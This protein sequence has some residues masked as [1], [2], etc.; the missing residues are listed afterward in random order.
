M[1]RSLAFLLFPFIL[2]S[3]S[4]QQSPAVSHLTG[5]T[6]GTSYQVSIPFEALD[7]ATAQT[8]IDELLVA[9]NQSVSTY[10][11]SS[12]ISTINS[13]PD[14]STVH[15]LD[16]MFVAIYKASASIFEA[17]NG[18]FNPAIG[19]LV[20]AYGFGSE[21][22]QDLS[23]PVI[24][25][26]LALVNFES[27]SLNEELNTLKKTVPGT[28]L[29]FSA[30]AKGYGV[31]LVGEYL[32][33]NGVNNYFVEIGGEVRT[34]G[35]HPENRP[36]KLG[37]DVPDENP[38]PNARP[39]QAI[40][41]MENDA[42]ATS[43]NYR[44]FYVKDGKKYVHTI[45]PITGQPEISNLLSVTVLANDCATAD[46]YATA[47]MVMGL[48]KAKAFA[49]QSPELEA[50]FITIGEEGEFVETVTEGFPEKLE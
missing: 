41:P 35:L 27:F 8:E 50:Y 42:S 44:N 37:I 46:A 47:F 14:T 12:L 2:I 19:P 48:D 21:E 39:L 32:E 29:D 11:E 6:M 3:C 17:T 43:G 15:I 20:Q 31:D 13:S 23:A 28:R 38:A 22:P 45:N 16:D 9:L 40:I 24:D 4:Q 18:A 10:I 26:L 49:D 34:R 25:S 30:I 33:S 1:K 5:R 7:T 36:W